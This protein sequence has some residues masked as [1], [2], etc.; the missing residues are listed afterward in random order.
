MY[1]EY[2]AEFWY[3]AKA[4]ENSKVSFLIPTG[5]IFREVGVN[6]F[7]N[8]IGAHYLPHSSEYV[9]PPSID[10][11]RQWF[12][13]IGYGEEVSLKG[14]LIN[15]LLPPRWRL[16]MAQI[17]QCLGGKTRGFDQITNE[18]AII[19]YSLANG[20]Y[21]DYANIF[22]EDIIIKLKKKQREKVVPYTRFLSLLIM[23]K[24]KEGYGDDKVTLYPT[25]V[26]NKPVAF[27]APKPTSNVERVP[28]GT[29]PRAKPRH[30][31]HSSSTQPSVS[32]KEAT[33]GGSYKAP[34]GS[35][36][37]HSKKRKESSSAMDSNPSQ[38]SVSTPVDPGMH[39]EDQQATGG[40]TSLGVTSEARANP[41][42][43][44]GMSTFNLNEPIYSASFIIHFE[45]ASGNDASAASTTEVDPGN[46]APRASSVASQIEEET[47]STIKL[48]D[49]A[50]MVSHVEPS[51]KDLDSP[52]DD[53]VI[54]VD[55]SDEDKDDEVH[56]T[57]NVKTEDTS[58]PKSSSPRTKLK[59]KLLSLKLN[60]PI[61]IWNNCCNSLLT[62]LKDLPSKFKD[63]T[64]EVKGLKN[65]VQYS[66]IELPG[67][68]KEIPL[69]L[70]DFTKIVTNLTSQV[71]KLKILSRNCQ[72][73]FL[74][75]H[76]KLKCPPKGSS[77]TEGEH[78]KKD[79]GKKALSSEEAM[80]ESTESDSDDDETHLSGSMVESSRIKKVKKFDFVTE[81]GKHIHLTEEQINQQKKIEEK[82]KAEAAKRESEVRKEELID[83]LGLEVVNKYYND[84]LQYD[85]YCDKMLN[86]E[87][88]SK[89][90]ELTKEVK[91]LK[92]KVHELEIELPGDLEEIPTKL[93][94]F[95]KIVAS[96]TSQVASVQAKLKTLDALPCLLLN[97]TKALNKFA[98]VLDS[99]S[100]KARDQ[101]RQKALSLEEVEKES[102]ISDSD[103][104]THVTSSMKLEEDAKAEAAKQEGEVRKAELVD[105]LGP[106]VVKKYYNDKLQYDR[107]YDK[108][109][110]RIAISRITNCDDPLKKLN[111][112][113]NK[114]RKHAD[115]IHDYFKANKRLKSSVQYKDHLPGTELNEPVLGMIMFNSYHRQDFVTIE[116]LKDFSNIMLYTVQEIF[117]RRHQGP[118]LDDHA[119]TFSSLL[120]AEIDKRNLNSLKQMR[121]IEQLRQ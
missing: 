86:K 114:K 76:Q 92:K 45:S 3:S 79:K 101:R 119:K 100:S 99:A 115:D 103:D 32:S 95:T 81:D 63:L 49:L 67:D 75:C 105:L 59:L 85:R 39:K 58:V 104:E 73:N 26:F 96:L 52:E 17:I 12:P 36:T 93:E 42:L 25:Q 16:L 97:V 15:S 53:L 5:G 62:E 66:E 80:K 112:L 20:I 14:T 21:I 31:K 70:E 8:D 117:F 107:Y 41:Q 24:L 19:L 77:Q 9:A 51:F 90:D 98:Q 60:P 23:H 94:D 65:Q 30:K 120:L 54:V 87:Y 29:K 78:I 71:A 74:L 34:T 55:D 6:T 18:D 38:P 111:D 88:T 82:A 91:W 56:A 64:K 40:P 109:L 102:T 89:F 84:K 116:D 10:V 48:E 43:S 72:L 4:L 33:K 68:L 35:K 83:L 11:V 113:A 121:V 69:K 108:M 22:W 110:N 118:G 47:S 50:K 61:P 28:Q 1:K 44:S 2:L 7:R 13:M 37:S 27:K 106:E 57:K 46:S